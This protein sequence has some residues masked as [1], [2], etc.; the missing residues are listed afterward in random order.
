VYDGFDC[1]HCDA[2]NSVAVLQLAG[3]DFSYATKLYFVAVEDKIRQT[4]CH[5]LITSMK[6][7]ILVT[8]KNTKYYKIVELYVLDCEY[9]QATL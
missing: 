9:T 1:P 7:L 5:H 6:S 4:F 8:K 2:F 3:G